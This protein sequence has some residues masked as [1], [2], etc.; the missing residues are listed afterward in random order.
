VTLTEAI[1]Q[2]L[3]AVASNI[4]SQAHQELHRFGRSLGADREVTHL[5]PPEIAAYAEDVVRA[6]GDTA[7]RLT[8]LKDFLVYLKKRNLNE[9]SLAPHVKI[10]RSTVKAPT[11]Q[12]RP[13][14]ETITMTAT[15]FEALQVEL[16]ELKGQRGEIAEA[17]RAAAAD[18]DLRENA[19]YH[20]AR[21]RQG[22]AEGRIREIEDMLRRAVVADANGNNGPARSRTVRVGMKVILR[23][24]TGNSDV[25]YTLVDSNEADP[26]K[27]KIST[28]SPVGKAVMGR[29]QGDE[30]VVVA[31]RG[32]RRYRIAKVEA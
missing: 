2:Y 18:K 10:P 19:P 30:V 13:S 12:Q 9:H 31:P 1:T 11:G 15:G 24:L 20:A 21:E 23:D 26:S 6:G 3:S 5:A 28:N 27:G 17:I 4:P 22:A 7:A 16:Q 29:S 8:A 32:E 14:V 25:T